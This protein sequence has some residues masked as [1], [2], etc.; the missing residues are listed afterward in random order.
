MSRRN[1]AKEALLH[2]INL[3]GD[4]WLDL[5]R[6][7]VPPMPPRS[8]NPELSALVVEILDG[9]GWKT[10][11]ASPRGIVGMTVAL[12]KTETEDLGGIP[13]VKEGEE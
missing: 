7:C 11:K 6:L 3:D 5:A 1:W 12:V 13:T 8:P 10:A 4:G 9:A 2:G